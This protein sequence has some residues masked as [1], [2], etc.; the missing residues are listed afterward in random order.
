MRKT[1]YSLV[2]H[3]HETVTGQ[4]YEEISDVLCRL[5]NKLAKH[6][7]WERSPLKVDVICL[8]LLTFASE[9]STYGIFTRLYESVLPRYFVEFILS[10]CPNDNSFLKSELWKNQVT[11]L[12]QTLLLNSNFDDATKKLCLLFLER[13]SLDMLTSLFINILPFSLAFLSV[14]ALIT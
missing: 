12:Y 13:Y 2:Q 4:K 14:D 6:Y 10:N 1:N 11:Q 8:F 9:A 3:L 7:N 5:V